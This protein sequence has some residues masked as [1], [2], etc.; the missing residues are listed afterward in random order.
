MI[1][2]SEP[3]ILFEKSK[4]IRVQA[5]VNKQSD[6]SQAKLLCVFQ[7]EPEDIPKVHTE[8]LDNLIKA[9]EIEKNDSVYLSSENFSVRD[10]TES[11]SLRLV[12]IFG[13]IS[14]NKNLGLMEKNYPYD[15]NDIKFIRTETIDKLSSSKAEKMELWKSLQIALNLQK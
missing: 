2:L 8:M 9:C 1:H 6:S 12:I 14:L 4:I 11:K 5:P 7:N 10:I 13:P 3:T 15:L